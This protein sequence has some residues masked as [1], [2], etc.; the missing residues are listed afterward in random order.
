MKNAVVATTTASGAAVSNSRITAVQSVYIA[1]AS[2]AGLNA[3]SSSQPTTALRPRPGAPP[4]RRAA[5]LLA[6]L[7]PIAAAAP[8]A[9]GVSFQ[10]CRSE[11][12]GSISCETRPTGNTRLDDE[13]ARFGLFQQASPGWA[14]FDPYAGD[15]ALFGGN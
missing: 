9:A 14:E 3:G 2:G 13:A 8:A 10:N 5:A 15:N 11:A 6:L 7:V 1:A 4:W 12:D